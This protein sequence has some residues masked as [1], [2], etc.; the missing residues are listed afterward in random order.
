MKRIAKLWDPN[1]KCRVNKT[2]QHKIAVAE[3]TVN[4]TVNKEKLLSNAPQINFPVSQEGQILLKRD[5]CIGL[6]LLLQSPQDL[7][8]PA[9]NLLSPSVST[10]EK[11][12]PCCFG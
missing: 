8:L 11:F 6:P 12:A 1:Y 5:Y 10:A 7:S 9:F 2:R 4:A 3:A